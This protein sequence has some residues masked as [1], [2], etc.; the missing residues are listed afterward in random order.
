MK[1]AQEES[2]QQSCDLPLCPADFKTSQSAVI[3]RLEARI[4]PAT[5]IVTT[6]TD[7]GDGSLR[8]AITKANAAAG[9]DTIILKTG[10]HGIVNLASPLPDITDSLTIDGGTKVKLTIDAH[11]LFRPFAIVGSGLDVTFSH[12]R[13][14]HGMASGGGGAIAIDD[15]GGTVTIDKTII[16]ANQA[17][18]LKGIAKGGGVDNENATLVIQ[19]SK[20]LNNKA[21]ADVAN[22]GGIYNGSAA[23]LSI[24]N[25]VVTGNTAQGANGTDGQK[26]AKGANGYAGDPGADGENG[27]DGSDG[28][29]G[30]NGG[31]GFGGGVFNL[32]IVTLKTSTVSGN[33]ASGGRGGDGGKGGNG[34]NGGAG[35]AAYTY[36]G[37]HYAAGS[38]GAGGS[39]ANG[40]NGGNGGVGNGG[41]VFN[42]IQGALTIQS[43]TISGNTASAGGAGQHGIGGKVGTG[44]NTDSYGYNIGGY[45][46]AAGLDGVV[47]DAAGGGVSSITGSVTFSQA[48]I[49]MN[50]SDGHG[51]GINL[52][53]NSSSSIHNSTIVGNNA[54]IGGGIFITLDSN[55]DPV[56]VISTI[57]ALNKAAT[58][59]DVSGTFEG[60]HDLI[61]LNPHLSALG[62]HGGH[63]ATMVPL[64]NSAAIDNGINV[65]GLLFDQRARVRLS[66]AHIDI[67]ATEATRPAVSI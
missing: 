64:K 1:I 57:I 3:E 62:K 35:G 7:A 39:G 36:Y 58:D 20:I 48:T 37:Y 50:T 38:D 21:T 6:L 27:E 5:L 66:G 22:G 29:N 28:E 16:I 67:G 49:A 65:D 13:I 55:N 14:S 26:G 17:N 31:S 33:T 53:Q 60:H 41:G 19:D 42:G 24:R 11:N 34:G 25:S 18:E 63:T 23:S 8:D 54:A 4:A 30:S 61:G 40:G 2:M 9:E 10:L 43:S 47:G 56:S 45:A 46:G 51:G 52:E 32:G 44:K 12:L 15:A 59:A